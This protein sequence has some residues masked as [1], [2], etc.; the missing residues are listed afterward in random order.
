[1]TSVQV[2]PAA[3]GAALISRTLAWTGEELNSIADAVTPADSET[4]TD[5]PS[6]P[7]ASA[8]GAYG[9]LAWTYDGVGNRATQV[10]GAATQ[11]YAYP[12]P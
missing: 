10:V 3:G 11:T 1:M 2:A 12:K 4:F 6:H 9:S 7:L 8:N 5:T